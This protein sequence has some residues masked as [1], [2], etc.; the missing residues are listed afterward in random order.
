MPWGSTGERH[1]EK[2]TYCVCVCVCVLALALF[3]H[4][5][6]IFAQHIVPLLPSPSNRKT[7]REKNGIGFQ[8]S[9]RYISAFVPT[10]YTIVVLIP[11]FLIAHAIQSYHFNWHCVTLFSNY[12]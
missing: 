10:M 6:L 5:F 12:F 7:Q 1:G 4:H 9:T 11:Q 2:A 8:L 3:L